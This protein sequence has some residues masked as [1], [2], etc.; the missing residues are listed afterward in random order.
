M[1]VLADDR[2]PTSKARMACAKW[3]ADCVSNGWEREQLDELERIWWLHH[4]DMG[5]LTPA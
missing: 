1:S 3:L 4:D 2:R 5:K